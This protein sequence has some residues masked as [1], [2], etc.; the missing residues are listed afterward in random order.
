MPPPPRTNELTCN[1]AAISASDMVGG[2]PA[3]PVLCAKAAN[4]TLERRCEPFN[5]NQRCGERKC[6]SAVPKSAISRVHEQ[7]RYATTRLTRSKLEVDVAREAKSRGSVFNKIDQ[8]RENRPI[9]PVN[10]RDY[11]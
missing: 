11:L 3:I 4:R 5:S 10:R 6:V 2:A 8:H 7:N 9:S 1:L